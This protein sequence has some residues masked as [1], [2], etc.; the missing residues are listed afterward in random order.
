V[1]VRQGIFPADRGGVC[2]RRA[3]GLVGHERLVER[4]RLPDFDWLGHFRRVAV[5]D[6]CFDGFDG[7]FPEREGGV[8][9]SGE[10][11]AERVKANALTTF[12]DQIVAQMGQ[13][14]KSQIK[15]INTLK[16]LIFAAFLFMVSAAACRSLTSVTTIGPNNSFILGNNKHDAY[17]VNLK[18][19]SSTNITVHKTPIN[20]GESLSQIVQPNQK[21]K[22]NVEKNTAIKID[23]LSEKPVDV[24][25]KVVGDTNLSMSYEN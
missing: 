24:A 22:V 3:F 13:K 7:G 9:K 19:I 25:L 20:G 23:N 6:F 18:N 5:G 17:T 16:K 21:I 11:F 2:R 14:I 4:L 10:E 12:A 1:A 8:G 15:F